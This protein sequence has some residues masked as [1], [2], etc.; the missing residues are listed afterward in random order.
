M[1]WS[2][3]GYGTFR[4]CP[5]Q[6]FYKTIF[7]NSRAKDP[8]R[9]E[10]ARLSKLENIPSWRGKIVDTVISYA[11]IPSIISK[12]PYDLLAA[13]K[14]ADEIFDL[15]REQRTV[16]KNSSASS[17]TVNG[18]FFEVEYG[19]LLN[20]ETFSNARSDI[21]TSLQNFYDSEDVWA[22]LNQ[23]KML[24]PQRALS[25]KD[26]TISIRCVPDLILFRSPQPPVIF[27]WKVNIHPVRDYWLQLVTG[28][29]ALTRCTHHKDWPDD[30]V[31]HGPHE[32][33]LQEVQ[34]L[35]GR[36][37][38]HQVSMEDIEDAED[39]I[40]SSITDMQFTC[41]D[42]DPTQLSP[43]AI[44]VTKNPT[45]CDFCSFRKLCWGSVL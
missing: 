3:S 10:A 29:I 22:F 4:R 12:Q 35:T 31:H 27:D 11:V 6:W 20:D 5:R 25:F 23:A 19:K 42:D 8:S 33:E 36:V 1:K 45:T 13:R 14:K 26:G 41:N 40:S 15:Q 39:T 18:A 37:I 21:Y 30:E 38:N 32:I 9:R 34:L 2:F 17:G 43:E 7:A 24:I 28:A 44:P 16:L